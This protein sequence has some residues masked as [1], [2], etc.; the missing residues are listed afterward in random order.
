MIDI[1]NY[2]LEVVEID[3]FEVVELQNEEYTVDLESIIKIA[4]QDIPV[5]KGDYVVTPKANSETVL[6]TSGYMMQNNVTVVE[7]PYA[8][9]SNIYGTTVSI[10][11]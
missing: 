3:K 5:Y 9:V 2:D 11:S 1:I 10:V 8:E 4:S 6:Q 7:I